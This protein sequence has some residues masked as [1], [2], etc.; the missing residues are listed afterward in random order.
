MSATDTSISIYTSLSLPPAKA[1]GISSQGLLAFF[2]LFFGLVSYC[3][4]KKQDWVVCKRCRVQSAS[5]LALAINVKQLQSIK[6][7][8]LQNKGC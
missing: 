1:N 8:T 3:E 7:G 4:A 6:G 5:A 2:C